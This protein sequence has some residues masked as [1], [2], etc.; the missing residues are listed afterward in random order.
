MVY[1]LK[2]SGLSKSFTLAVAAVAVALGVCVLLLC[3]HGVGLSSDTASYF[4]FA[5][6]MALADLPVHHGILYPL[7]LGWLSSGLGN[8]SHA[9]LVLNVLLC[10]ATVVI[11]LAGLRFLGVP[12]GLAST[13]GVFVLLSL[14]V[15][16]SFAWAMSDALFLF[17]QVIVLLSLGRW[18]AR[19]D[20][21][22]AYLWVAVAASSLSLLTRYA[23]G[24]LVLTGI[25]V[26]L[27]MGTDGWVRRL[28]RAACYAVFSTF[29]LLLVL[30]WNHLRHGSATNR[31]YGW[32]PVPMST[33]K[34]GL[35]HLLNWF[36]PGSFVDAIPGWAQ[37]AI[38]VVIT[39][40]VATMV[41]RV[42]EA[43]RPILSVLSVFSVT[44]GVFLLIAISVADISIMLDQRMLAPLAGSLVALVILSFVGAL[45]SSGWAWRV[46]VTLGLVLWLG[47][48]Y[49]LRAVKMVQRGYEYGW[50]FASVEWQG[51]ETMEAVRHTGS[52]VRIYSN[53]PDVIYLLTGRETAGLPYTMSPVS[54]RGRSSY[55][56]ARTRMAEEFS[57]GG[58]VLAVFSNRY[59]AVYLP[60]KKDLVMDLRLRRREVF[61]D[62]ELWEGREGSR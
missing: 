16:E 35:Y 22:A 45:W 23:G 46:F 40:V 50:G 6:S 34:M 21:S 12:S 28:L 4:R 33:L 55:E 2:Q 56:E 57:L 26:V 13:T 44:Y 36:L 41:L 7:I 61:S 5:R 18:A 30:V 48:L 27:G 38:V 3:R 42:H 32:H 24:A 10:A 19:A 31:D 52:D 37:C 1:P 51:S 59:W 62:G 14:P 8:P 58:A 54:H 53:A 25:A 29:P 49:G 60:A 17:L 39:V 43:W 11:W 47:G 9:A 20:R 15:L